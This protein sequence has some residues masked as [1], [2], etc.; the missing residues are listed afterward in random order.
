MSYYWFSYY[1]GSRW[2]PAYGRSQRFIDTVAMVRNWFCL[3]TNANGTDVGTGWKQYT[4]GIET[5]KRRVEV[6]VKEFIWDRYFLQD[7]DIHVRF[8]LDLIMR[9]FT[10]KEVFFDDELIIEFPTLYPESAPAFFVEKYVR[11]EASSDHHTLGDG[12]LCILTDKQ[13]WGKGDTIISG[14]NVALNRIAEHTIE[15]GE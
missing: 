10:G 2:N 11:H 15:Y 12:Q 3:K 7:G 6:F 9:W 14:I 13:E 8:R 1:K 5:K 4:L